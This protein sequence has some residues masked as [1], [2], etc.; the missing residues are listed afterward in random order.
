MMRLLRRL[1]L[2]AASILYWM[3]LYAYDRLSQTGSLLIVG[4]VT[5]RWRH[6]HRENRAGA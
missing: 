4:S 3:L 1:S 5:W 2:E 6:A